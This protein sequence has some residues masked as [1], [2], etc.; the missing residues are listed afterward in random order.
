MT[1]SMMNIAKRLPKQSARGVIEMGEG[2]SC[3]LFEII[4][5]HADSNNEKQEYRFRNTPS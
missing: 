4:P 2:D 5:R 1:D 3:V